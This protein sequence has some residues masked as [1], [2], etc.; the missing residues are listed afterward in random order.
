MAFLDER[1]PTAID[2]GSSNGAKYSGQDTI[3]RGGN[4]YESLH[5]PYPQIS[6]SL[7]FNKRTQVWLM[8]SVVD[9]FHKVGGMYG[10][11]FR[12]KNLAEYTTNA[13]TVTPTF[14]DQACTLVSA[15]VY[16]MTKWYGTE[17]VS[18]ATRRRLRKP[19]STTGL[20]GIRDDFNNPVAQANGFTIDY[21]S[22]EITFDAN[23]TYTITGITQAA[24]AVLT[25]GSH[26]LV[27]DDT[28]HISSVVGMTEINGLR[29]TVQ[30]VTGTTITVDID[31]TGFTAY[32]SAGTVNTRPQTNE[33]VTCGCE[34]DLPMRFNNDLSDIN[35][36][37]FESLSVN[38]DLIEKLNP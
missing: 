1:F 9:F 31:S 34:F 20:V 36:S 32:G 14:D 30:S 4:S 37:D 27:T 17:G 7:G 5:H 11:S 21:A 15:G 22:G 10:S 26:T 19:V 28:V 13:N 24:N 33:D 38:V 12:V 35:F 18:T 16:Q 2:Y 25:I 6:C 29:G 8:T 3:T 23:K